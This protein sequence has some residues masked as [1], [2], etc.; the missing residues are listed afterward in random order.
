MALIYKK[1]GFIQISV[2]SAPLIHRDIIKA[3]YHP[4]YN[5]TDLPVY[6]N[7]L[8]FSDELFVCVGGQLWFKPDVRAQLLRYDNNIEI[9]AMIER[10]MLN[11]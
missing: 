5:F 7:G 10:A 4:D 8:I 6:Y 1:S 2:M 3:I 11:F 9:K